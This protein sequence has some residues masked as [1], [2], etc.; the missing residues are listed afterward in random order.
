MNFSNLSFK[1][2]KVRTQILILTLVGIVVFAAFIAFYLLPKVNS[3]IEGRTIE[4]LQNLVD[5]PYGVVDKYYKAFETG[6]LSE[7]DA[8]RMALDEIRALRY[9]GDNYFW[10]NDYRPVMVMHPVKTDMDGQD[11]ATYADPEGKLIF[12]EFANVAKNAG[13]GVVR[14]S[15]PKPG[16]EAPQPK[17]SYVKGFDKWNWVVGT[18]I[19]IDDIVAI[20]AALIRNIS[21]TTAI[22]L[23]FSALV[24]FFLSNAVSAPLRRLTGIAREV[25]EGNIDVDLTSHS[26]NEIGALTA[27]FAQVVHAIKAVIA[28][29]NEL[30]NRIAFGQLNA[31][32]DEMRLS[33][34]W[35]EIIRGVNSMAHTLEGHI[36]RVPAII[37]AID[38]DFNVLYMNDAGLQGIGI[39]LDEA[40][41]S[42]C[43]D[44]FKTGD[45]RTEKC[46]CGRAIREGRNARSETVAHPNGM[47]LDIA[48]EGMPLKDREGNVIGAI[49]L[50]IDQTQIMNASRIQTK[51]ADYQKCEVEKL[52]ANLESLAEGNL[53][54]QLKPEP[55]DGDTDA[56]ARNFDTIYSSL[57]DMVASMNS[58]IRETTEILQ[59][60]SNKNMDIEITTEY[61]GDFI[62]MKNAI[63]AIIASL[64]DVLSEMGNAAEQVAAGSRQVSDGSQALS[65]GA[66]EQASA[67]EELTSSITQI[68]TQTKQ[69]AVN[70]G[71]A[72]ELANQ[73]RIHADQGN[74]Y[75]QG[76]LRSMA[77]INESS[78]SISKIIKVIDE[79]AFQTNILAL[80][81]A[82]EAA[83]AG[84]HGK[85]FAVVAE[86]VRNL[87]A[88]SA[89]AAK[90]TTAMIEGSI[91]KVAD[92]T[93]IANETAGA[94]TQI[95]DGVAKAANLV[96]EIA[97][98]SNEQ[99][100]AI[101]Q[102]NKGVEQVSQVV[103]TNSATAEQSAA[104]SEE[105]SSQAEMLKEMVESFQL[106]EGSEHKPHNR[107]QRSKD[108][109]RRTGESAVRSRKTHSMEVR[110][111]S[112]VSRISLS[113]GEFGKY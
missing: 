16:S 39:S 98:A 62:E 49:E 73:A 17:L 106:K 90:E 57:A 34:G 79:I 37:M 44:L 6:V 54:V 36:R 109:W 101:F 63:N 32:A 43:Y 77:E 12:V 103:Q 20:Q 72:N 45:C 14:Y 99:A 91:A 93:K 19:Y 94:L 42:K 74:Q 10:I 29:T 85:G 76:M 30:D 89:S 55:F 64:N 96:G 56:M 51:I 102:I 105:L 33:G 7:E 60:M 82:V 25:A 66:T 61:K 104:A 23:L 65:Q 52:I 59:E 38:K 111:E 107:S 24:S 95:V 3:T 68:A 113:D 40:R 81:A 88:R 46:A 35:Q 112:G 67:V 15:W 70:A 86:E 108:Q 110:N 71:Q 84:Q 69:N 4:K 21:I 53:K 92:G 27:A 1:N 47:V 26:A 48:Y 80:N 100:S 18:G 58:V 22:I 2:F 8:K 28:E 31:T 9:S 87:A 78:A 11:M 83:R 97:T 41:R 50:V 13:A 75:M 5:I